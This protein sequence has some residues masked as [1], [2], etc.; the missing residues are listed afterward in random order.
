MKLESQMMQT[1]KKFLELKDKYNNRASYIANL[2]EVNGYLYFYI[3]DILYTEEGVRIKTSSNWNFGD[4]YNEYLSIDIPINIFLGT[5]EDIKNFVR[6]KIRLE[7]L[8]KNP[9]N[10]KEFVDI[11]KH[12]N[13]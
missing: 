2:L 9:R 5:E 13:D 12:L 7:N 8:S 3:D 4:E 1:Y 6:V 11:K 10:Y